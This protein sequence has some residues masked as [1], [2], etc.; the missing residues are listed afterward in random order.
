MGLSQELETKETETDFPNLKLFH[1]ACTK[2]EVK[3]MGK[4]NGAHSRELKTK[5]KKRGQWLFR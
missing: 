3:K 2:K 5:L 4:R 1:W